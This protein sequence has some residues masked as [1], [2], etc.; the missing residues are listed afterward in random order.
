MINNE[1]MFFNYIHNKLDDKEKID[2]EKKLKSSHDLLVEF[3]N[4]KKV[5]NSI[6]EIKNIKLEENYVQQVLPKF[7]KK[8]EQKSIKFSKPTIGFAFSIILLIVSYLLISQLLFNQK[9]TLLLSADDIGEEDLT[10][11]IDNFEFKEDS[12]LSELQFNEIDSIYYAS[13]SENIDQYIKVDKSESNLYLTDLT[14]SEL[15][16]FISDED[17]NEIYS[18][19]LEKRIY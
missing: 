19:L 2:F 1:D 14:Y 16:N 12:L 10:N 8:I 17:L 13:L 11:F 18:V 7:R 6:N 15:E 5:I 3:E 9:G 4:Y